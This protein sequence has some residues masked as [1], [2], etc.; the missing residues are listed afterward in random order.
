MAHEL[1]SRTI[2]DGVERSPNRGVSVDCRSLA[3]LTRV[4][5]LTALL[6]ALTHFAPE[7]TRRQRPGSAAT[8]RVIAAWRSAAPHLEQHLL[9]RVLRGRVRLQVAI[10]EVGEALVVCANQRF[11]GFPVRHPSSGVRDRQR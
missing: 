2:T 9:Y 10:R 8:V 11:E 1:R 4:V 5:R 6:P 3:F 7:N